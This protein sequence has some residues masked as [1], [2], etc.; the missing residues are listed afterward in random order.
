MSSRGVAA[1]V[2]LFAML[3]QAIAWVVPDARNQHAEQLGHVL[4]HMQ[5]VNHH[6][7]IDES[8]C[9]EAASE[10]TSHHHEGAAA[11]PGLPAS[12]SVTDRSAPRPSTPFAVLR[13]GKPC[14]FPEGPLR[15]P[16]A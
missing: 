5:A 16:R 12:A 15:P 14:I 6:H 4:V 3:W 9:L 7:L 11:Q 2:F 10:V 13:D 8:L 1:A